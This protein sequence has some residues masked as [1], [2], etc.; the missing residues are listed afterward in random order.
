MDKNTFLSELRAGLSGLPEEGIKERVAFYEEMIDD[1]MED[2]MSEETAVS[3]VGPVEKVVSEI[4]AETPFPVIVKE[5]VSPKRPLKGL[6]IALLILASPIWLSLLI[7]AFAV[8]FSVY[9]VLWALVISLWAVELALIATA[10]AGIAGGIVIFFQSHIPNRVPIGV[11]AIGAGLF[12]A[13]LSVFLFFA[14][15]AASKGA[16]SLG[17]KIWVGIKSLFLRKE[18]SK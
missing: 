1:R 11:A 18:R 2:G 15:L 8:L 14:C 5:R 13:G 9:I 6:E 16:V 12:T 4:V 3:S 10:L 17:K 7:A